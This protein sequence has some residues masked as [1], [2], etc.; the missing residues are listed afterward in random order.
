MNNKIPFSATVLNFELAIQTSEKQ[1]KGVQNFLDSP[2]SVTRSN[3]QQ[4]LAGPLQ[5][6]NGYLFLRR[7]EA[8]DFIV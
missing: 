3:K 2:K 7:G 1:M 5:D 4:K 6:R 8:I